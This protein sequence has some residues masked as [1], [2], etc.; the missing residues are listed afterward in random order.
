MN[1]EHQ[2]TLSPQP[3]PELPSTATIEQITRRAR[4]LRAAELGGLWGL[5]EARLSLGQALSL[6]R[7]KLTGRKFAE[8]LDEVQIPHAIWR[9][10]TMFWQSRDQ[11]R[12]KLSENLSGQTLLPG[13]APHAPSGDGSNEEN[14]L[15]IVAEKGEFGGVDFTDIAALFGELRL[16]EKNIVAQC[17][18]NRRFV[19]CLAA[20][21]IAGGQPTEADAS[22]M[23]AI[24][25]SLAA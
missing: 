8:F 17:R 24:R 23:K 5:T 12:L 25:T 16:R 19:E 13:I 18:E 10:Y 14:S 20:K 15:K 11:V 3:L 7:E 4:E 1:E 22:K 21:V 6:A 2:V 9:T